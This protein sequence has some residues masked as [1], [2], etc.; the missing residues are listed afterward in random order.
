MYFHCSGDFCLQKKDELNYSEEYATYN[1]FA[2]RIVSVEK[3]EQELAESK[4]IEK[5]IES[6]SAENIFIEKD[7]KKRWDR[8]RIYGY[9]DEVMRHGVPADNEDIRLGCDE[10]LTQKEIA[11]LFPNQC[12]FLRITEYVCNPSQWHKAAVMYFHCSSDFAN[13]K[14]RDLNYSGVCLEYSTY[15]FNASEHYLNW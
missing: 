8:N 5:V 9:P 12:V 1:T 14:L 4:E 11:E 2:N 3:A 10:P 7:G 15:T 13:R 6:R